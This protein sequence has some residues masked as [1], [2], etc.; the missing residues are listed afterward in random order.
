MSDALLF[1]VIFISFFVFRIV[2][3]TAF[4]FFLLPDGDRCPMCDTPTIR[5]QSKGWNALLPWF[6]TSWCYRCNW[7]GLLRKGHVSPTP[8]P[9]EL[10]KTKP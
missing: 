2:A 8:V 10:T 1:S 3:A 7:E 9:E 5:V 6:R 4:F